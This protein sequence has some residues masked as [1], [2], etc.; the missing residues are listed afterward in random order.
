MSF[1]NMYWLFVDHVSGFSATKLFLHPFHPG[2]CTVLISNR[3]AYYA[4]QNIHKFI[5]LKIKDAIIFDFFFSWWHRSTEKVCLRW[6]LRYF[7][8]CLS[9]TPLRYSHSSRG[10][11]NHYYFNVVWGKELFVIW[12][13]PCDKSVNSQ[14]YKCLEYGSWRIAATKCNRTWQAI[15]KL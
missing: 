3:N 9:A 7:N 10:T 13:R 11:E 2:I 15:T 6:F 5:C 8:H 1:C 12:P 14:Y 4:L